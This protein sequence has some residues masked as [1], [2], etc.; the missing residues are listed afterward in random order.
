M[1]SPAKVLVAVAGVVVLLSSCAV[2]GT[3]TWPGARLNGTL[4]TAEDF[5]SGVRYDR[6]FEQPGDGDG[7]GT[8]AMMSE[9]DGCADG[10]TRVIAASAER[11]PGSAAKYG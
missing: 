10:L 9:P 11:G 5:P 7:G 4:L 3:P 6:I 2:K 1:W 8:P